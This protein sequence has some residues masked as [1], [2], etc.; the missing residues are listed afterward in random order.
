VFL[1]AGVG[2]FGCAKK[3]PSPAH[4]TTQQTA[5]ELPEL[6]D[7]AS[8]PQHSLALPVTRK[9]SPK[10][11]QLLDEFIEGHRLEASFGNI[12]FRRYQQNT[13]WVKDST[14]SAEIKKF[15]AYVESFKK[16]VAE[17][18][19]DY[20]MLAAQGYL[21]IDARP[22]SEKQSWGGGNHAGNSQLCCGSP[23][24]IPSVADADNNIHAGAKM[25]HDI[26]QRYFDD[27]GLD[28]ANKT[29]MTFA[30]YNAGP[31]RISRLRKR[32]RDEGLDPNQW[33]GNVELVAFSI[34]SA[35]RG[36]N[37]TLSLI[38]GADCN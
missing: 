8:L 18:N 35:K 30:A 5:I 33:F 24:N 4:Q 34:A 7:S 36:C 23:V 12:L 14:T 13:K 22:E 28:L 15:K 9:D 32:A 26:Q 21:G 38:S 10:L 17:Y 3:N 25:L 27:L 19:F 29:L 37:C 6:S 11:K 1:I 20:L 2:A 31:S 16:Y